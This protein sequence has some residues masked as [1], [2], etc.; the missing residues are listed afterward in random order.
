MTIPCSFDIQNEFEGL[1][2]STCKAEWVIYNQNTQLVN[3]TTENLPKKD[4]TTTFNNMQPGHSKTYYFRLECPSRLIWTY[5]N[6]SVKINV[7][8]NPPSPT[9][10]PST[11]EV[12]EG[13]SVRLTC[14][15]PAPCPSDPPALTWSPKLGES[16]VKLQEN[17]DKT[18]FQTSVLT[19]IASHSHDG[20]K[21]S[22]TAVYNK[23]DG[24][25]SVSVTTDLTARILFPPVILDSSIC[26]RAANHVRCSCET[27]G[28]SLMLQWVVDGQ[29]VIH[30]NM[31]SIS[32]ETLNSTHLKSVI[33]VNEPQDRNLSS[34]LCFSFNSVGSARKQFCTECS[35]TDKNLMFA[36]IATTVV[37]ITL[38]CVLLFAIRYLKIQ[39]NSLNNSAKK[40]KKI[41]HTEEDPIYVNTRRPRQ[42]E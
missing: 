29:Q 16:Q 25:P 39:Q 20:E 28:S 15:A 9:L 30:S 22:C 33:I 31:I 40:R 23:Q 10:T 8:D 32:T 26:T 13:T 21:I 38:V 12:K 37:L 42:A 2:I 6:D 35:I 27:V 3:H 4:C 36:F 24:N 19:F 34:L 41:P 5:T 17:Q 7:T 14:S 11:L 1:L 18:Q